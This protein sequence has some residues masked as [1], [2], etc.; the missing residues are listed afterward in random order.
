MT[1][2]PNYH[3]TFRVTRSTTEVRIGFA[4]AIVDKPYG[5]AFLHYE[6]QDFARSAVPWEVRYMTPLKRKN[7]CPFVPL[8]TRAQ[9]S[10]KPNTPT[11]PEQRQG[12]TPGTTFPAEIVGYS[13]WIQGWDIWTRDLKVDENWELRMP[14]DVLEL[15]GRMPVTAYFQRWRDH[16]RSAEDRGWK[17]FPQWTM[18]HVVCSIDGEI[19]TVLDRASGNNGQAVPVDGPE[20][21]LGGIV[22]KI[23]TPIV[24]RAIAIGVS[25]GRRS[26]VK[27]MS[28]EA[29]VEVLGPNGKVA[30]KVLLD[31][32]AAPGPTIRVVTRLTQKPVAGRALSV[33]FG[34]NAEMLAQAARGVGQIYIAEIPK[35]LIM[36]LQRIGL[37]SAPITTSMGGVVGSEYR[38]LAGASKYIVPL[39]K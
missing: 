35:A 14:D 4:A 15:G 2:S 36:H 9:L 39:F 26:L 34:D 25:A 28:K 12:W 5:P 13:G 24:K 8:M 18:F 33:A 31:A 3:R 19:L 32:L 17:H 10:T 27:L 6:D 7:S 20:I 21:L 29:V 38:F 22:K 30:E 37:A 1:T 11:V 16:E 23:A